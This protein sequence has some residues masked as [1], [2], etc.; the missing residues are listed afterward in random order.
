MTT[1][2]KNPGDQCDGCLGFRTSDCCGAEC[3]PDI[4]ICHDCKE[5]CGTQCEDCETKNEDNE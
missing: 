1:N 2:E 3:D 4:L 5:H